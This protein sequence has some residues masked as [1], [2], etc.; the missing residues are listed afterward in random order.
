MGLLP[1]AAV[2]GGVVATLK[3]KGFWGLGV[4]AEGLAPQRR[5]LGTGTLEASLLLFGAN[6]CPLQGVDGSTWWSACGNFNVARLHIESHDLLDR[7][8]RNE[9]LA[10]PGLS[11]RAGWVAGHGVLLSGGLAGAFPVSPDRYIYRDPEGEQ[12]VAFEP[13]RLAITANFGVGVLLD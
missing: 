3:P 2:G 9:W 6:L 13:S 12:K 11:A 1:S 5:A 7:K 8:S 10:L 4:Q